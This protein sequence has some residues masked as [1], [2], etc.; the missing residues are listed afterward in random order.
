MAS[1][2]LVVD[3]HFALREGLRLTLLS[4]FPDA[5]VQQAASLS[6]AVLAVQ[7]DAAIDLILLDLNLTDSSGVE[8]LRSLKAEL[9]QL[10]REARILV[11][12]AAA[13]YDTDAVAQV[14]ED[15]AVGYIP[16][17]ASE[18]VLHQGIEMALAGC[19]FVPDLYLRQRIREADETAL[20]QC[21]QVLSERERQIAELLILGQTYKQVARQLESAS[22]P[23]SDN[24]IR[25]H[26][27]RMAWKLRL[28]LD[29]PGLDKLPAKAVV[30]MAL[31]RRPR[32]A[33]R[34]TPV[35]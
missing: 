23:L 8:T 12:S 11:V 3:D 2:I 6:Q 1:N 18:T 33:A 32:L 25:V 14:I 16:K 9:E 21:W 30:M 34:A 4:L 35:T 7:D 10:G 28:Q 26:T 5:Q 15:C 19:V 22:G 29:D 20:T 24:T 17:N 13:D 31:G 27:Q